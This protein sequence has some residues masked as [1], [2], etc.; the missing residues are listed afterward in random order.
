GAS[1]AQRMGWLAALHLSLAGAFTFAW[2]RSLGTRPAA[3]ILTG[4]LF[5]GSGFAITWLE[6]PSFLT[7]GC[8]IPLLL[9]AV[10]ES[11]DRRSWRWA[12]VAAF[13][14][15]MMLLGG[16]LQIA[17]YGL[18]AVALQLAWEAGAGA[19]QGVRGKG[20]GARVE[21]E[22]RGGAP[23]QLSIDNCQLTIVNPGRPSPLP[24]RPRL[25]PL[26]LAAAVGF[27]LAAAQVLPSL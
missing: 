6:L 20:Q 16:H 22:T 26:A 21:G 14:L 5:M 1:T 23:E 8:W 12:W 10:C 24:L 15:G 27:G 18:L 13:A 19:W 25:L 4:V 11:L 3:A 7:A 9:R 17:F 2:A